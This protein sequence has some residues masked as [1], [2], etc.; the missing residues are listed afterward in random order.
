GACLQQFDQSDLL[1]EARLALEE[2]LSQ[3]NIGVLR[4]AFC[5]ADMAQVYARAGKIESACDSAK[6]VMSIAHTNASLR[7][8]LLTLHT[9]LVPYADVEA[10]KDL[11]REMRVVL[12]AGQQ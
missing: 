10:V 9:L 11:D 1:E 6:Q 8:S 4:R 2:V 5:M 12:L 7:Q 3:P